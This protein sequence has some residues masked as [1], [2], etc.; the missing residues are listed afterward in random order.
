MIYLIFGM[1]YDMCL[2]N[3][4]RS[5]WA[6][7][8]LCFPT[9]YKWKCDKSKYLVDGCQKRD[10]Q[11]KFLISD[12]NTGGE[13]KA[14]SK[15]LINHKSEETQIPSMCENQILLK[16]GEA[17]SKISCEPPDTLFVLKDR[18]VR[19]IIVACDIDYQGGDGRHSP[20]W[21]PLIGHVVLVVNWTP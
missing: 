15:I 17:M 5:I 4:K 2:W 7:W 16:R 3:M 12:N 21:L 1:M 14:M 19:Y 11:Y 9:K 10:K 8:F 20:C 13:C 6:R 18:L